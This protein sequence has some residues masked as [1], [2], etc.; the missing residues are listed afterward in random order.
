MG[1]G[2]LGC[3]GFCLYVF[4]LSLFYWFFKF[5]FMLIY[6]KLL[7]YLWLAAFADGVRFLLTFVLVLFVVYVFGYVLQLIC[8]NYYVS[9]I[10]VV[11]SVWFLCCFYLILVFKL[12]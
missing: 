10:V 2:I 4:D 6:C 12:L 11:G 9:A 3:C 7:C 8:L 5:L 1:I